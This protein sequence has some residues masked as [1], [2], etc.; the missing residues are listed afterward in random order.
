MLILVNEKDEQIGTYP[1]HEAHK[2]ALLHRAFSV[3][4]FNSEGELL[5]QQRA[6]NKYHS[7]G[8]WTNTCCSHPLPDEET[9][10][11]AKRRLQ[12]E[13]GLTADLKYIFKFQYKAPLDNELFEH[14]ID[15]VFIGLSNM[16]P[17]I[18]TDEV[19]SFKYMTLKQIQ[20]DIDQHPENYTIWFRIIFA[21][22][23]DKLVDNMKL[24]GL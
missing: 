19:N 17:V 10:S 5:M 2:E 9:I 14:E 23:L 11:A 18:N 12:E 3:F 15:H 8:L 6:I 7:G 4:I 24:V 1:K 21:E 16:T 20:T 13:M 22:S